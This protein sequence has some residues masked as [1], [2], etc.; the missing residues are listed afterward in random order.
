[1]GGGACRYGKFEG[2]SAKNISNSSKVQTEL[3][4][5]PALSPQLLWKGDNNSLT[6]I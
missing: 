4:F 3:T 5:F 1:M 6:R 2:E